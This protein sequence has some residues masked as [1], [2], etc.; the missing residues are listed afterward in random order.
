MHATAISA[1][2]HA[3]GF[4]YSTLIISHV[5]LGPHGE[6][7][8]MLEYETHARRCWHQTYCQIIKCIKNVQQEKINKFIKSSTFQNENMKLAVTTTNFMVLEVEK[9]PGYRFKLKYFDLINLWL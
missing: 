4:N 7:H 2:A 5:L 6:H 1:Q 3:I 9:I 8:Y